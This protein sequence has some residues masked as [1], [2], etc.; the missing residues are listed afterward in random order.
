[1]SSD[2]QPLNKKIRSCSS[3]E[4]TPNPAA[5]LDEAA[6]ANLLDAVRRYEAEAARRSDGA[7]AEVACAKDEVLAAME[8]L[9]RA[10][11]RLSRVEATA[12]E[13]A[14]GHRAAQEYRTRWELQLIG[15]KGPAAV[16]AA[17]AAAEHDGDQ[18]KHVS[19]A[20]PQHPPH[21]QFSSTDATP[22]SVSS[23]GRK[24]RRKRI[25]VSEHGW[26]VYEGHL[27]HLG[28]P[29]GRGAVT[30]ENGGKYDGE[31]VDGKANGRGVMD[32]G[33]GDRYEGGWKDGCRF[34]M[35]THHFKDGG[36]YEGQWRNAAPDGH[37][38]MTL[39]NGS[40]YEG[41]WKDGKWHGRGIV[42]PVNGGEWEGSFHMGKCTVGTLRRPNGELEVGR[43]DSVNPDDVKEGVWWSIDRLTIW[44][45]EDGQKKEQIDEARAMEI[46]AR[47]GL[48]LPADLQQHLQPLK[49]ERC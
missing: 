41:A 23:G 1:M 26:G 27:D 4:S 46:V 17:L 39:K 16:A 42:R 32:Y 6:S 40:H 30:W 34:G 21:H 8:T 12:A 43:Y 18:N 10:H 2:G 49:S 35:G 29:H 38:K 48:P 15:K 19:F 5:P 28:E 47:L 3:S 7:R 44:N 13:A 45:V 33:N 37:G 14:K 24:V 9:K 25:R 31:W 11:D 36:V 20:V 22:S